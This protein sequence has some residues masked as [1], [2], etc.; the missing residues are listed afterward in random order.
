MDTT[1]VQKMKKIFE[2]VSFIKN[3]IENGMTIEQAIEAY[4]KK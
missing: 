3:S 2:K 1:L 4:K